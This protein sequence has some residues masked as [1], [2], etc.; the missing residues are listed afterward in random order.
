MK[1]P[2][3]RKGEEVYEGDLE[4]AEAVLRPEVETGLPLVHSLVITVKIK[5]GMRF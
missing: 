5:L 1:G 2:G 4:R 3:A